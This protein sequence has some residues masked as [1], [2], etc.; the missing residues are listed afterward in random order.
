MLSVLTTVMAGMAIIR[1]VLLLLMHKLE[2]TKVKCR[3]KLSKNILKR[4][5]VILRYDLYEFYQCS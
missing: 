4:F 1:T 3:A 5:V 2:F